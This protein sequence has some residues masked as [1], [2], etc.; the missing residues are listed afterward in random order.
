MVDVLSNRSAASTAEW[1]KRHP[2]IEVISRD[3]AGLYAEGAREGAPQAR[4]VADRFHPLQNFREAVERQLTYP[5]GPASR[6]SDSIPKRADCRRVSEGVQ[7]Q[8]ARRA[9]R[10]AELARFD[11]IKVLYEAGEGITAIARAL[12]CVSACNFGSD[13]YL[14]HVI[15][16]RSG[17]LRAGRFSRVHTFAVSRV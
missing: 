13:A 11:E 14:V 17:E 4:Q 8:L 3:R 1:L 12:G 10:A 9:A 16:L 6:S 2:T 15:R 5:G 7:R